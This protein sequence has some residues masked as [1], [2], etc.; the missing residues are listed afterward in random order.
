MSHSW[1]LT[2]KC[3]TLNYHL[4]GV[5]HDYLFKGIIVILFLEIV[6]YCFISPFVKDKSHSISPRENINGNAL[7]ASSA[8]GNTHLTPLSSSCQNIYVPS[9]F[10][11]AACFSTVASHSLTFLFSFFHLCHW[12]VIFILLLDIP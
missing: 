1:P 3:M 5:E 11:M 6:I 2:F 9:F 7:E 10:L 8:S 12:F 4:M